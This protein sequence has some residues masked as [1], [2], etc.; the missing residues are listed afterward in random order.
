VLHHH[1]AFIAVT[2][3][4]ISTG[5]KGSFYQ[6]QSIPGAIIDFDDKYYMPDMKGAPEGVFERT[7]GVAI[8]SAL[9]HWQIQTKAPIG[10]KEPI[11]SILIA[12]WLRRRE[13]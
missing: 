12:P 13:R 6:Q 5:K 2:E 8:S 1:D 7:I 4:V 10:M 11:I 9:M 3:A